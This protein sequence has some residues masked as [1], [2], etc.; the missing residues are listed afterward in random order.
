[1]DGMFR[2]LQKERRRSRLAVL[3][4]SIS[5]VVIFVPIAFMEWDRRPVFFQFWTGPSPSR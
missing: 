5:L 1:M 4:T 3:A 2:E